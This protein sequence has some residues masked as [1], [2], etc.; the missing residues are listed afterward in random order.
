MTLSK[1]EQETAEIA[2]KLAPTLKKGDIICLY[3]DLGAGKTLFSRALIRALCANPTLEVPS[4]TFTLAQTYER[5]GQECP[6]WHFDLYRLEDPEE[7][8]E[9]G[10][11]DALFEGII[12]VEWPVRLGAL[13]PPKRIDITIQTIENNRTIN[14]EHKTP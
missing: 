8:Y 14:I 9:I 10:W 11:Q 1:S 7:I 5:K 4:P 12:L 6:I 2:T 3:G 13:L